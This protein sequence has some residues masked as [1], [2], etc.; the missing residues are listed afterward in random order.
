MEKLIIHPVE[1]P[2]QLS[3]TEIYRVPVCQDLSWVSVDHKVKK[4]SLP[5]EVESYG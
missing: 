3:T 2:K 1:E 4:E 5:E